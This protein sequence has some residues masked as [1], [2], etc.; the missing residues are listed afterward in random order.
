MLSGRTIG[1]A[2]S[3]GTERAN[4]DTVAL[5]TLLYN[6]MT[7]TEAPVSGG[8]GAN[9]AADYAANKTITLPDLRGRV[10]VGKD[11]MGGSA[12]SRMT[13]GGSGVAGATL[14]AAGGAQTHTLTTAQL[15]AHAH[16]SLRG[17]LPLT[18]NSGGAGSLRLD[19]FTDGNGTSEFATDTQGSGAAHN[20]TQPSLVVN[21]IIKL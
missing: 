19:F 12:A 3:G 5:F 11:D 9:A 6:S 16:A 4:A 15:A 13:S 14:G 21:K 17:G 2:A 10:G 18:L 1:N 7:N 20:N 8:R